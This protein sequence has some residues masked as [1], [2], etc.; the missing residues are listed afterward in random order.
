MDSKKI[1]NIIGINVPEFKAWDKEKKRMSG[2]FSF[3]DIKA[4]DGEE[5]VIWFEDGELPYGVRIGDDLGYDDNNA[6]TMCNQYVFLKHVGVRDKK[7]KKAFV[8]DIVLGKERHGVI[9][10]GTFKEMDGEYYP[11]MHGYYIQWD[12]KFCSDD[13]RQN[14]I[15]DI[16]KFE[17]VGNI[18]ENVVQ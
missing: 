3:K 18:F 14:S 2:I 12:K 9:M 4:Y 17:I 6:E 11:L 8:G 5:Q 15:I 7:E 10:E 1:Q 13:T 16:Q